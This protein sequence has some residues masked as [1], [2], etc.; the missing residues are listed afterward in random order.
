L[1][2][3][4]LSIG[5]YLL[6]IVG[7]ALSFSSLTV[8]NAEVSSQQQKKHLST[9]HSR[10]A[11]V[12][13]LFLYVLAPCLLL[14]S[15]VLSRLRQSRSVRYDGASGT[16][17]LRRTGTN[18]TAEK[19]GPFLATPSPSINGLYSPPSSPRPRTQSTTLPRRSLEGMSTDGE[20][21]ASAPPRRGFEVLNRPANRTL[22]P[23]DTWSAAMH[24]TSHP[25]PSSRSLG[26]IDWLLRR[27]SLNAVVSLTVST[28]NV[29][30]FHALPRANSITH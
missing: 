13:F 14:A 29:S 17:A 18:T 8:V 5:A 7:F 30:F 25:M 3:V 19:L 24:H 10:A 6:G 9:S 4:A 28:I 1:L 23:A 26:E 22:R 2:I 11:L 20:S 27:R 21:T 16:T 12:F 15:F